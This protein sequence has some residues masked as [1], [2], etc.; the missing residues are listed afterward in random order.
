MVLGKSVD[1]FVKMEEESLDNSFPELK[2]LEKKIGRKT[3]DVLLS[4]MKDATRRGELSSDCSQVKENG[5]FG[6]SLNDKIKQLKFEMGCL[7]T[8]DVNILRQ[9]V[10]VHEGMEVVR[11]LLEER[12]ALASHSSSLTGSQCSLVDALGIS[13]REGPSPTLTGLQDPTE[14]GKEP[15]QKPDKVSSIC[16]YLDMIGDESP[17][18]R[19]P[20]DLALHFSTGGSTHIGSSTRPQTTSP[21]S[22]KQVD[23]H[24]WL[25]E[26]LQKTEAELR[27]TTFSKDARKGLTVGGFVCLPVLTGTP[28]E[29]LRASENNTEEKQE[30]SMPSTE[31]LLG[32]DAQWCW[33][34][35]QDDVTFL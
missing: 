2:D 10:T 32:Y 22:T 18:T 24:D 19:P 11:W 9:L 34:E 26:T 17:E 3:P 29:T 12:G 14:I 13:P 4:W 28:E 1:Q 20:S 31:M 35:S 27:S 33:V 25:P 21:A 30:E 8:A 7:R 6:Q 23:H 16:G 5:T 15:V